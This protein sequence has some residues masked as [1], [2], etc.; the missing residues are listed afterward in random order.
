MGGGIGIGPP[1]SEMYGV[2]R[3]VQTLIQYAELS[4]N[5]VKI[6]YLDEEPEYEKFPQVV[7][8]KAANLGEYVEHVGIRVS[9]NKFVLYIE[10][11]K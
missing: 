6:V 7:M 1:R 2:D 3:A 8:L 11:E 4:G 10:K 5:S 9:D